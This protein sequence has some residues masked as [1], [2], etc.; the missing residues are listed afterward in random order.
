MA[1][2]LLMCMIFVLFIR[3]SREAWI[4][5]DSSLPR[6][7]DSMAVG[8]YN[9][10]IFIIGGYYEGNALVEFDIATHSVTDHGKRAIM[11]SKTDGAAQ[12]W[13]QQGPILYIIDDTV[14]SIYDMH[15]RQ[16]TANW[17]GITFL[18]GV[19]DDG[20]LASSALFLYV[21]GGDPDGID[22][23]QVLRLTTYSWITNPLPPTMQ[24]RRQHHSCVLHNDYLWAFAGQWTPDKKNFEI[25]NN[26]RILATGDIAQNTWN[27]IDPLTVGIVNHR[28]VAYQ[29]TIYVIGG[30]D[31][32]STEYAF[33]HLV[34]ANTGEVSVSSD[35]MPDTCDY[36]APIIVDSTLYVF[37]GFDTDWYYC[38]LPTTPQI[39]TSAVPT[40]QPTSA[41]SEIPTS[42]PIAAP[43]NQP[44]SDPSTQPSFSPS[45]QPT[46]A[47]VPTNQPTHAPSEIPTSAPI[48]A[49]SE[50][51]TSAPV[52]APSDQPTSV[53][54]EHPTVAPFAVPSEMP[55]SVPSNQPTLVP[56]EHPTGAP[57]PS[58]QPTHVPSEIPSIGPIAVPTIHP[59]VAPIASPS[60]HPSFVPSKH[61][62]YYNPQIHAPMPNEDATSQPTQDGFVGTSQSNYIT[63]EASEESPL[64]E[65]S[66][67]SLLFGRIVSLILWILLILAAVGMGKLCCRARA[68]AKRD[69]Q[70][71]IEATNRQTN[72]GGT[73]ST[74]TADDTIDDWHTKQMNATNQMNGEQ[75]QG[76]IEATNR[77]TNTGGTVSTTTADD[78]ID[79]W[80]TKQMNATNQ[81]NGE[82]GQ[83][84][85]EATNQQTNTAVS[86]VTAV[87]DTIDAWRTKQMN[88]TNQMNDEQG[89]APGERDDETE[90]NDTDAEESSDSENLYGGG[91]AGYVE[92]RRDQQ[93]CTDCGVFKMGSLYDGLFYCHDCAAYYTVTPQ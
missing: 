52:A 12:F 2:L 53:P 91:T 37:G 22:T 26:E 34:D 16:F 41:P 59:S 72:T 83:G 7:D 71:M 68:R 45:N 74:T 85:I 65:E 9:G 56:S 61:P 35:P 86:P 42:A 89:Q 81:M 3:S 87:D 1:H 40:K 66:E 36:G 69:E 28:A 82:Q 18:T 55:T 57:V 80:H 10:K 62:T 30:Q 8:A 20:C 6:A 77:Q 46:A 5:G 63:T 47:P 14:F 70:G 54:S 64:S 11:A 19:G 33:V 25:A 49:P 23:L 44:T 21:T 90:L 92:Q 29:D 31:L 76:M 84:M 4:I 17:K 15:T 24:Q 50:M 58:N 43:S 79:D 48:P 60:N 78:T 38:P 39:P 32:S 13:S 73:V 75:G 88:V 93:T 27:Y 51:P 67:E